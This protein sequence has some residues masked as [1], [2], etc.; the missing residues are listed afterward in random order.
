MPD[1]ASPRARRVRRRRHLKTTLPL[2]R[3]KCSFRERQFRHRSARSGDFEAVSTFHW[4][5]ADAMA[6]EPAVFG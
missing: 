6:G 4:L 5:L 2:F 1:A 3:R